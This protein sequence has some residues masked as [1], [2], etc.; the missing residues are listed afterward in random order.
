MKIWGNIFEKEM[1]S[2]LITHNDLDGIGCAILGVKSKR[3]SEIWITQNDCWYE[4]GELVSRINDES[5]R[6]VVADYSFKLKPYEEYITRSGDIEVYDHHQIN[7]KIVRRYSK[8]NILTSSKCATQILYEALMGE[9]VRIKGLEKFI[10]LVDIFD[11]RRVTH[12]LWRRSKEINNLLRTFKL[13]ITSPQRL[14]PI[15]HENEPIFVKLISTFSSDGAISRAIENARSEIENIEREDRNSFIC[16]LSNVTYGKNVYSNGTTT[17]ARVGRNGKNCGQIYELTSVEA[18]SKL[19]YDP[20]REITSI[21]EIP[22]SRNRIFD[23]FSLLTDECEESKLISLERIVLENH[24]EF[25]LALREYRAK[26]SPIFKGLVRN[27]SIMIG[28]E[29]DGYLY[30]TLDEYLRIK[31]YVARIDFLI[32]GRDYLSFRS[33]LY[34]CV[35][36]IEVNPELFEYADNEERY[37]PFGHP[38]GCGIKPSEELE[39]AI[40]GDLEFAKRLN[41]E[42]ITSIMEIPLERLFVKF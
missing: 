34:D 27:L 24:Q 33:Y 13:R 12:P 37:K 30:V 5:V 18:I 15:P 10:Q 26:D 36:N 20:K 6:V 11:M 29:L 21:S 38:T 1:R 3:F 31:S 19:L 9:G 32:S 22:F 2:I 4:S 14:L 41:L 35:E 25:N 40:N 39:K 17:F 16:Q 28:R 7:F 42:G 8:K 23:K